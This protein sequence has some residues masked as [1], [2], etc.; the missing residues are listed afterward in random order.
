[1]VSTTRIGNIICAELAAFQCAS[2]NP[3]R[4]IRASRRRIVDLGAVNAIRLNRTGHR[5]P[6]SVGGHIHSLPALLFRVNLHAQRPQFE[7]A[8]AQHHMSYT[9]YSTRL[10][11]VVQAGSSTW[12]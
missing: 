7:P 4:S 2:S 6:R 3:A 12:S 1:M 11:K 5:L 8:F 9:V 10:S